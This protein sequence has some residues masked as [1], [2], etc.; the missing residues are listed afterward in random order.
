MNENLIIAKNE[1]IQG[2]YAIVAVKEGKVSFSGKEK[3]VAALLAALHKS[4][5][6]LEGADV[7]DKVVGRA[8]ALLMRYGKISSVFATVISS[9][10]RETLAEGNVET[11]F[12]QEVPY[13]SNRAKDG[14]CPM[15]NRC[16]QISDPAEAYEVLLDLFKGGVKK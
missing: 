13:I 1:L 5:A 2:S 6:L 7:A 10:A 4:P 3:G 16:L 11:Y 8:A 9:G 14:M 12:E 15:E